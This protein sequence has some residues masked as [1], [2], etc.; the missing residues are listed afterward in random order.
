MGQDVVAHCPFAHIRERNGG[1]LPHTV[2][3]GSPTIAVLKARRGGRRD[4]R[5]QGPIAAV[6]EDV[7][8]RRVIEGHLARAEW[9][10]PQMAEREDSSILHPRSEWLGEGGD[11]PMWSRVEATKREEEIENGQRAQLERQ[12]AGNEES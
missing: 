6:L 3:L 9:I 4:P 7:E 2:V 10:A 1:Q 5:R 8:E 12:K 11:L